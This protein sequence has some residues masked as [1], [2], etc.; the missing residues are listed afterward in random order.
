MSIEELNSKHYKIIDESKLSYPDYSGFYTPL[1]LDEVYKKEVNKVTELL[2]KLSVE[3]AI[4]VLEDFKNGITL[5][6]LPD[7][8]E[9]KIQELKQYLN[10]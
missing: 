1:G 8:I 3:Y 7:F 4:S 9:D 2:T 6:E 5:G 10:E